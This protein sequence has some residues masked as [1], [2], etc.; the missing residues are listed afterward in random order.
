MNFT[1]ENYEVFLE[2]CTMVIPDWNEL[3]CSNDIDIETPVNDMETYVLI[4][5]YNKTDRNV[6]YKSYVKIGTYGIDTYQIIE[7]C[8]TGIPG[9]KVEIE[10]TNAQTMVLR[11]SAVV[12]IYTIHFVSHMIKQ[13]EPRQYENMVSRLIVPGR[14]RY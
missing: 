9:H 5:L 6:L 10:Y 3:S 7:N 13:N 1:S 11:F 2:T 8:F 4:K 12:G 14:T